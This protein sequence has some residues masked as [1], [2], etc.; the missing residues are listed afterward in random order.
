[1]D[2]IE[3]ISTAVHPVDGKH[4]I[5]EVKLLRS[6]DHDYWLCTYGSEKKEWIGSRWTDVE[7]KLKDC[8]RG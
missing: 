5:E 7:Q 3:T 6:G 8:Q 1:M 4:Y 2:I